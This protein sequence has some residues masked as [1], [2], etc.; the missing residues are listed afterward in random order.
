MHLIIPNKFEF[1]FAFLDELILHFR[2]DIVDHAVY[3]FGML[4]LFLLIDAGNAVIDHSEQIGKIAIRSLY[5][6]EHF[7]EV[8]IP[9]R[10][11]LVSECFRFLQGISQFIKTIFGDIAVLQ[12]FSQVFGI[13]TI[14]G[15]HL[16]LDFFEFLNDVLFV[17]HDCFTERLA[18]F[19]IL[20]CLA[21]RVT[22]VE[23]ADILIIGFLE[24]IL[25]S[26]EVDD[27]SVF[28]LFIRAID[29]C[30]SLQEIMSF[31]LA[32]EVKSFEA[33]CIKAGEQHLI[34][35]EQVNVVGVF[36]TLRDSFAFLCFS[37]IM[38]D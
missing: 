8:V 37:L 33:V 19:S 17:F 13:A 14:V 34:D 25:Y 29:A 9:E 10:A 1:A 32:R 31:H 36:E 6:R 7:F 5:L 24:V 38:E 27:I 12:L 11:Y 18:F 3:I 30:E 28:E 4:H 26:S 15:E 16:L 20:V 21:L 35:D 23:F 22:G 2:K